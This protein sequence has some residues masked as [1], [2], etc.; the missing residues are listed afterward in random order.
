[1]FTLLVLRI[2]VTMLCNIKSVILKYLPSQ[3]SFKKFK[4]RIFGVT[5]G[6]YG[7]YSPLFISFLYAA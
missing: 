6:V 1:M 7:L 5:E 2:S 3:V 4:D